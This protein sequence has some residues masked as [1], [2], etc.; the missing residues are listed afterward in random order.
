MA[1]YLHKHPDAGKPL[2]RTA[3]RDRRL[4]DHLISELED[5]YAARRPQDNAW[6]E[7]V[8]QYASIPKTAVRNQPIPNAP[9]VEFPLS[10]IISDSLYAQATDTLFSGNP[11]LTCRE[12]DSEWS[13]H[14]KDMQRF[15]NWMAANEIGLRFAVDTVAQDD[16]QLGTG[17]LYCPWVEEEKNGAVQKIVYRSPR[18]I[19]IAPQDFLVPGGSRGDHQQDAWCSLRFWYTKGEL[20]SQAR[21]QRWDISTAKP[22]A[23]IDPTRSYYEQVNRTSSTVGQRERFEVE[24]VWT[25][26]DYFN[27]GVDRDLLV[28]FDRNSK[29]ILGL[30]YN[31]YDTRPVETMR[32]QIR[33]HL[34][35]GLGVLEMVQ[36]FQ[37]SATEI[38]NHYL[39]NMMLV[40]GRLLMARHGTVDDFKR[41]WPMRIVGVESTDDIKELRLADVYPSALMGLQQVIQAAERRVGVSGDFSGGATSPRL[42]GTRT[43]GITAMTAMQQVNRR[44][45]PAFDGLRLNT[46]AAV[47]QCL[48]RYAERVRMGGASE[49]YVSEHLER[50]LGPRGAVNVI[51]LLREDDFERCVAVEFTAVSAS[52]NR[53]ADRQNALLVM[54]TQDSYFRQIKEAAMLMAQPGLPPL[55]HGVLRK[56]LDAGNISM[57]QFLRTFDHVRN[58]QRMLVDLGDEISE[59]EGGAADAMAEG[60]AAKQIVSQVMGAFS[61]V[62]GAEDAGG[63]GL[64]PGA[65]ASEGGEE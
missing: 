34:F 15:V 51:E 40:N 39:L 41:V 10:A 56:V 65:V 3:E 59:A 54:Q 64:I 62:P 57:D 60:E 14:A 47:R 18:V 42:L 49:N 23:G 4:V 27:D 22:S 1:R 45:A 21:A 53:E 11:I 58:P 38:L 52:I 43:P 35:W 63:G 33:P 20:A 46:A 50:L 25:Y 30:G 16:I 12:M 29:S 48:W 44:F 26:F 17:V 24:I 28:A 13:E 36:P 6:T 9:N 19:P 7:G 31:R 2:E 55:V 8:R 32:Y 61:G 37:E 5:G